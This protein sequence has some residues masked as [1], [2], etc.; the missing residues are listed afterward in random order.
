MN[1]VNLSELAQQSGYSLRSLELIFRRSVGMTPG[2]W[3][4]NIR[5]NGALRDLIAPTPGCSVTDVATRWGFRHLSRFAEQYRNAF[6][7]LPSQ[8]LARA[9]KRV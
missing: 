2:R 9:A 8:T 4:T 6:G 1:E 7:E 3:F 5:L